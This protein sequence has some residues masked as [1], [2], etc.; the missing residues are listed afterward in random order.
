MEQFNEMTIKVESLF[1]RTSK[2][3][4]IRSIR[5]S[6]VL[7]KGIWEFIVKNKKIQDFLLN[8][9]DNIEKQTDITGQ[10]ISD[11]KVTVRVFNK[12]CN[13]DQIV[14]KDIDVTFHTVEGTSKSYEFKDRINLSGFDLPAATA[15][16]GVL[17]IDLIKK[18]F[19][20]YFDLLLL[21]TYFLA[22]ICLALNILLPFFELNSLIVGIAGLALVCG[23][24]FLYVVR[25]YRKSI[26]AY[27][28]LISK[29]GI[30]WVFSSGKDN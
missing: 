23:A 30:D 5:L 19:C 21:P 1:Y 17:L 29:T 22:G 25:T 3:G 8:S 20:K 13:E 27:N 15:K 7:N 14:C 18:E 12:N 4:I 28:V 2:D 11:A 16:S 24:V 10:H 9:L 26:K 6:E